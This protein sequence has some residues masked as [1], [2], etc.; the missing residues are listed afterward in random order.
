MGRAPRRMNRA[1]RVVL[2]LAFGYGAL[3]AV[4]AV[5]VAD[6]TGRGSWM[7]AGAWLVVLAGV[8]AAGL[9]QTR[10]RVAA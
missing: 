9:V 3:G 4:C 6:V 8:A 2:W 1:L 10:R 7:R 5:Y